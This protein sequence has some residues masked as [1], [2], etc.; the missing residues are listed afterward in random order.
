MRLQFKTKRNEN[1]YQ[2]KTHVTFNMNNKIRQKCGAKTN[3]VKWQRGLCLP[4]TL[5]A[6]YMAHAYH[7]TLTRSLTATHVTEVCEE[8]MDFFFLCVIAE[9]T[10]GRHKIRFHQYHL[11]FLRRRMWTKMLN[12]P[13]IITG[14][15]TCC[16]KWSINLCAAVGHLACARFEKIKRIYMSYFHI[17]SNNKNKGRLFSHS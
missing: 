16:P 7:H 8:D 17:S 15:F 4:Q 1:L 5:D 14:L 6:F 9:W 11:W 2:H 13:I 12:A 3:N 10:T